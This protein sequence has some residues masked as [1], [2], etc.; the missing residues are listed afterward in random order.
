MER[1]I[2]RRVTV[3]CAVAALAA[4]LLAGGK[5]GD[6]KVPKR[7][8]DTKSPVPADEQSVAQGKSIYSKNCSE[9]HG[10]AGKGDGPKGMDLEPKPSD[11][12]SSQVQSQSEGALFWKISTGRRPMPAFAKILS[13]KDRWHAV[14]YLRTLHPT[15]RSSN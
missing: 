7:A 13:E 6:W 14:N 5:T 1:N 2:S 15:T 12:S 9:C 3:T 8:A 4:F 11:L 10:R